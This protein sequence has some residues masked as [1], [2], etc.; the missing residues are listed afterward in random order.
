MSLM[1]GCYGEATSDAITRD[2]VELA[3]ARWVTR[4]EVFL[5]LAGTHPEIN[6]PRPGAIARR[7]DRGLGP[8]PEF[9]IQTTGTTETGS[10]ARGFAPL[11]QPLRTDVEAMPLSVSE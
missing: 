9:S 3:D 4:D 2:P 7:P 8:W 11:A 6:K 10:P 5:I 1:F